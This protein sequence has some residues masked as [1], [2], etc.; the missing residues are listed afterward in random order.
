MAQQWFLPDDKIDVDQDEIQ[1]DVLIGMQK[2]AEVFVFFEITRI[3]A[4]KRGLARIAGKIAYLRETRLYEEGVDR[5]ELV[6]SSIS[7]SVQGLTKLVAPKPLPVMDPAFTDGAETRASCLDDDLEEW[8]PAYRGRKIDGL[9]L[10]AAWDED[11]DRA[12]ALAEARAVRLIRLFGGGCGIVHREIGRVRRTGAGADKQEGHEHFGFADGVSQPGIE[13]LTLPVAI[14]GKN[15]ATA[16]PTIDQGFPGQ[17]LVKPGDFILGDKYPREDGKKHKPQETW[18][19][20]GSYLVFRRL[21]QDVDAFQSYTKLFSGFADDPEQFGAKIV[22]RWKNGSPVMRNPDVDEPSEDEAHPEKNNDFDFG[23]GDP[24]GARCPFAAH[25]RKVYPRADEPGPP[26]GGK[27]NAEQHRIIRAGIAFGKDDDEDK[28]LLFLCYQSD[29][30]QKFEFIQKNWANDPNFRPGAKVLTVPSTPGPDLLIGQGAAPRTD[31]WS[32]G[33]PLPAAPRF[34]IATGGAYLF[35]PSRSGLA[36]LAR[37]TVPKPAP[38][39]R[40]G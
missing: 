22:G 18:L 36:H 17:D 6:K 35:T 23:D 26:D 38:V 25:I 37:A 29:I 11:S 2:R 9:L 15:L 12:L 30:E 14:S 13:G 3:A 8:L 10:V 7:F 5:S 16:R 28:G 32:T 34:V 40:G 1:G 31:D 24:A 33:T 21:N 4:F 27:D 19:T 39:P 20:N